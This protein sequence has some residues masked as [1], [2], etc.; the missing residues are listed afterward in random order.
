MFE[1]LEEEALYFDLKIGKYIH[2]VI[3]LIIKED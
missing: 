3:Y 1:A 2:R